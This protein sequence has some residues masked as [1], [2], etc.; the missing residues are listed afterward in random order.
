MSQILLAIDFVFGA[1][2]AALMALTRL[3]LSP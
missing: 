2:A 3:L 1:G